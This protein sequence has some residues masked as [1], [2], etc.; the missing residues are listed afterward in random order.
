[1][2]SVLEHDGSFAQDQLQTNLRMG[3]A[4]KRKLTKIE[5]RASSTFSTHDV[6][7]RVPANSLVLVLDPDGNATGPAG[8]TLIVRGTAMINNEPKKVAAFRAPA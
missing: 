7:T 1:M 8:S 5:G 2:A 4:T 6:R 3:E